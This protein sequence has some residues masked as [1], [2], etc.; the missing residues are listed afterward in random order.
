MAV[1]TGRS[2]RAVRA[3]PYVETLYEFLHLQQQDRIEELRER[4]RALQSASLM[5]LAFHEPK[6]LQEEHRR[7]MVDSGLTVPPAVSRE[8]ALALVAEVGQIDNAGGWTE[9]PREGA[10]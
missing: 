3:A 7:L 8:H 9:T 4:G 10:K 6:R 2:I 5:A 1:A